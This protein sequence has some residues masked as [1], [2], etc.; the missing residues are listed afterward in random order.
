[1]DWTRT[2]RALL[3]IAAC[4]ALGY[5][6]RGYLDSRDRQ[7]P[8]SPTAD[9]ALLHITSLKDGDSWA[10]SD[11]REYRL[12]LVNAP[13]PSELCFREAT[14]FTGRFLADGFTADAYSR[15]PHGRHIAEVFNRSGSSLNVALAASG[16]ADGKYLANFRRENPDLAQRV[17]EALTSAAT[18]ACR[19]PR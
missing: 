13:E 6:L 12:G 9:T 3:V 4:I 16:L 11:G 15:D 2:L 10:A 14:Q 8:V 5:A 1:V 7:A 18:P 17:E 19:H